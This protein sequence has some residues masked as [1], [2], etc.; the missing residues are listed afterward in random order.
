MKA[1]SGHIRTLWDAAGPFVGTDGQP[2][3]RAAV[4]VNYWLNSW[5]TEFSTFN[6]VPVRWFV[7]TTP[8]TLTLLPNV[9]SFSAE[10]SVDV[11]AF[12]ATIVI[13]NQKM[14]VYGDGP[15][16]TGE[17]GDPGFYS[18]TRG[19][20]P[21]AVT[22]WGYSTNA[23]EDVLVENALIR[24]FE[25]FGGQTKSLNQ[26]LTDGNL[27]QTG[28]W[29]VDD[30]DINAAAN[31][32]TL[33]LRSMAKLLVDQRLMPPLVPATD[34]DGCQVYPLSY[35]RYVTLYGSGVESP[36]IGYGTAEL[37]DYGGGTRWIVGGAFGNAESPCS[38]LGEGYWLVG[39]DGGVFTLGYLG[40]HGSAAGAALNHPLT[41][42]D[43]HPNGR[44]YWLVAEDGGVFSYGDV[45]YYGSV[46][47]DSITVTNIVDISATPSGAG[48][49]IFGSNGGVYT[50]GNAVFAG[51][52][53]GTISGTGVAG[54]HHPSV[55]GYWIVTHTGHV[56][57]F[58]SAT[59]YGGIDGA[60]SDV[61]DIAPTHTG[62][63]YY[64]LRANGA[65]YTYGDA[66]Y[67]GSPVEQ[68]ITLNDDAVE[69]VVH[70]DGLGYWIVAADGGVFTYG[71]GMAFH[72]SLPGPWTNL[73]SVP[74]AYNDLSQ[75][76]EELLL[77]SGFWLNDGGTNPDIH[78]NIEPTG[79]FPTEGLSGELF[80]KKH[81]IDAINA[82]KETVGFIFWVDHEGAARFTSPN[83]Y[84]VGNWLPSGSHSDWVPEI[85]EELQM[86]NLTASR[87]HG[88][89][90]SSLDIVSWA[91]DD[92]VTGTVTT[93]FTPSDFSHLKG[94]V[95]PA[96]H[97]VDAHLE[98]GDVELMA[99]LIDIHLHMMRRTTSIS[100]WANPLIDIDDQVRIWERQS[101]E[102]DIYYVRSI[103][104][105][106]DRSSGEYTM[107]ITG[108]WLADGTGAWSIEYPPI[109]AAY[110]GGYLGGYGGE[111]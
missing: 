73:A 104:R 58:G 31:T 99:E 6:R 18:P 15:S 91:A 12:D 10:E 47:D 64:L 67:H 33:R 106:F 87:H 3:V 49:V 21:D 25:G 59:Y 85:D 32:I 44:G 2:D 97:V 57:A 11:D 5:S 78:G 96:I 86:T 56:Y 45:G 22:R 34:A 80:D 4:E 52:G 69:I 38:P 17:F 42:M 24:T 101:G 9:V 111:A 60:F 7:S 94:M 13:Q 88:F 109:P 100:C 66:V 90:R 39:D 103:S 37:G 16:S 55:A 83:F 36:G 110:A 75:V 81:P 98:Q 77:W 30:I 74:T 79:T 40:F 51:S 92:S 76:I 8:P 89:L 95:V 53:V 108:S 93:T 82:I 48:Y 62:S 20:H 65:V 61:V 72:G 19:Q 26:A 43:S 70:P 107:T 63:G 28:T 50:Y 68:A 14:P 35:P 84:E 23:W 46:P 102:A 54:A 105:N 27:V 41:G 71:A 29:L 1:E